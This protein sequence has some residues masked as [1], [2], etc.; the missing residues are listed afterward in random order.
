[1]K[2]EHKH[3]AG[4]LHPLPIPEKKWKVVTID[5]IAKFLETKIQHD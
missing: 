5:I 1:V 4:L 3:S 2:D